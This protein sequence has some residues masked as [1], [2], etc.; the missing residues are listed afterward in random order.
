MG[1]TGLPFIVLYAPDIVPG[2]EDKE[3]VINMLSVG[4]QVRTACNGSREEDVCL[5][6]KGTTKVLR[7]K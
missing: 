2:N 1:S 3:D 5:N 7:E 6:A 4:M